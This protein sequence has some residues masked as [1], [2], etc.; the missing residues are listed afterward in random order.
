MLPFRINFCIVRRVSRSETDL[1]LLSVHSCYLTEK[2]AYV[3]F[4]SGNSEGLD[5]TSSGL[6]YFCK[7]PHA[8]GMSLLT[9]P[10][11]TDLCVLCLSG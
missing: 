9:T 5:L 8:A 3:T 7:E 1:V 6:S 10:S 4:S 2:I 11:W